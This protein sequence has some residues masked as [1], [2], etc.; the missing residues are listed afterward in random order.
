MSGMNERYV[1]WLDLVG[2]LLRQPL[3]ALPVERIACELASTLGASQA[4]YIVRDSRGTRARMWPAPSPELLAET[5]DWC[6][7]CTKQAEH[8]LASWFVR[9]G[10]MTAQSMGS[11]PPTALDPRVL[12]SWHDVAKPHGIEHQLSL[13]VRLVGG[14]Y[15]AFV[16]SRPGEDFTEL[17]LAL[18]RRIQSVLVGLDRQASALAAHVG[19][20]CQVERGVTETGLSD[21]ELAVLSLLPGG[22]TATA[23]ARRLNISPRTVHKHLENIY[24]KLRTRDR[25]T[26]V[27]RAQEL[28]LLPFASQSAAA[29]RRPARPH[30]PNGGHPEG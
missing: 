17:D 18:A 28:G 26:T 4:G 20:P 2:E 7:D 30:T 22:L 27:L 21:R 1:R 5:L 19:V 23:I 6:R 25:L 29:T 8:P 12:S 15:R 11:L 3:V 9:S 14:E 16:V 10:K 24:R 13:P